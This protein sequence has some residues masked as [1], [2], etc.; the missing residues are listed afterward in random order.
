MTVG[1]DMDINGGINVGTAI[2]AEGS[3]SAWRFVAEVPS[4]EDLTKGVHFA[5]VVA[6]EQGT[7]VAKPI[8]EDDS[9]E[10]QV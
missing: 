2:G 6:M 9:V 1:G 10:P 3:A 8:C 5:E 7:E 4:D